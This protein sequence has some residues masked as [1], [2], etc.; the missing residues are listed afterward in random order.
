MEHERFGFELETLRP[1]QYEQIA[2]LLNGIAE[3]FKWDKVTEGNNI[4]GLKQV[5]LLL[6]ILC[7]LYIISLTSFSY[8]SFG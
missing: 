3:R 2:E 1:L 5:K 8:L 4:I 6:L 7:S